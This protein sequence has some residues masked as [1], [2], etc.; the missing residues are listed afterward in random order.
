[1]RRGSGHGPEG[2][3][4]DLG[5][6]IQPKPEATP[7]W[8]KDLVLRVIGEEAAAGIYYW[9]KNDTKTGVPRDRDS[10]SPSRS[11]QLSA[12]ICSIWRRR[13]RQAHRQHPHR[14]HVDQNHVW[15]MD[16]LA[17]LAEAEPVLTATPCK[18][19][20]LADPASEKEGIDWWESLTG[21]GGEGMSDRISLT[22]GS[23]DRLPF[24]D[25]TFASAAETPTRF[26]P[27]ALREAAAPG[28]SVVSP[29]PS[30]P[31]PA[32]AVLRGSLVSPEPTSAGS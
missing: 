6:E 30:L 20:E 17:K 32:L 15:H 28:F 24:D 9:G 21:R 8:S 31:P 18:V 11:S 10:G 12:A 4:K 1:V 26:D 25:D 19:I 29:S 2:S 5:V 3:G 22:H 14:V 13:P 7:A 27:A 16:T 23:A